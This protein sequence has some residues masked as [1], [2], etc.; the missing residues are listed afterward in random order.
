MRPPA[1]VAVALAAAVT[2]AAGWLSAASTAL[3]ATTAR[4]SSPPASAPA[5]YDFAVGALRQHVVVHRTPP[6]CAG[7]APQEINDAVVRA[8]WTVVGPAP[9]AVARRL[10]VANSRYLGSLVRPAARGQPTAALAVP[11]PAGSTV[12]ARIAALIAWLTAAT[13]GARLLASRLPRHR[14]SRTLGTSVWVVGGHAGLATAGLGLW[15]AFLLTGSTLIGW[16]DV[17]MTWVIAGLGM[18]TLLADP[19]APYV[20]SAGAGAG[21]S[22]TTSTLAYGRAPVLTIALHG[23][24]AATT[25]ALVLLGVLRVG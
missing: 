5:C 3:A 23:A 17:A 10:A 2:C 20:A 16:L 22:T 24:L 7:L 9:K 4:T 8:I 15:V 19:P 25:M 21:A 13:A 1:A 6:A 18:A 14:R 11:N 12:P